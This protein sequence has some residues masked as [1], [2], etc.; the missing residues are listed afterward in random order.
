M[1]VAR[2]AAN[3]M[4]PKATALI[5]MVPSKRAPLGCAIV[6]SPTSSTL[7]PARFCRISAPLFSNDLQS[8]QQSAGVYLQYCRTLF[9]DDILLAFEV[10]PYQ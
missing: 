9:V 3:T 7:N 4:Q 2:V 10:H 8:F 6:A 1:V 5:S